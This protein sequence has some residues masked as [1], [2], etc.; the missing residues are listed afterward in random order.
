MASPGSSGVR[1][2]RE[3]HG[4]LEIIPWGSQGG[5]YGLCSPTKTWLKHRTTR[6][7]RQ[8]PTNHLH[9][10]NVLLA[11]WTRVWP[12]NYIFH[13]IARIFFESSYFWF[14]RK[15]RVVTVHPPYRDLVL[16]ILRVSVT[17]EEGSS[18]SSHMHQCICFAVG[19]LNRSF[20]KELFAYGFLNGETLF[21]KRV[22]DLLKDQIGAYQSFKFRKESFM[23][24][25]E[26]LRFKRVL[27]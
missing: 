9:V 15:I 10:C 14:S 12:S 11:S 25:W 4:R 17:R 18:L 27:N 7:L 23:K 2:Y 1:D 6:K 5:C 26:R 21:Y 19:V 22:R 16:E 3:I 13:S 20:W 8:S 24:I